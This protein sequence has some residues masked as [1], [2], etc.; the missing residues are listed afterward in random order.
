MLDRLFFLGAE[1]ETCE[2]G[3]DRCQ[4]LTSKKSVNLLW[5][6]CRSWHKLQVELQHKILER[7]RGLG[8]LPVRKLL[9]LSGVHCI[10]SSQVLPGFAGQVPDAFA[11]RFP[12]AAFTKQTWK[13]FKASNL[14][15]VFMLRL[16]SPLF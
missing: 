14:S 3:A 5:E 11:R 4:G 10:F 15:G 1:W 13:P 8:M 9:L 16:F 12:A 7:M 6:I 2:V